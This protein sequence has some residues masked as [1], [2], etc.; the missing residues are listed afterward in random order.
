MMMGVFMYLHK[1]DGG[2]WLGCWVLL[3]IGM[4]SLLPESSQRKV[5][6][7]EL[8]IRT[9]F[10]FS[11]WKETKYKMTFINAWSYKERVSWFKKETGQQVKDR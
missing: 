3:K 9:H 8:K 10:S 4:R 1:A 7:R 2:R 11:K 5:K 6:I